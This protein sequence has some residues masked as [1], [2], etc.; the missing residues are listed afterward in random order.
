MALSST[1]DC[2]TQAGKSVNTLQEGVN[3]INSEIVGYIKQIAIMQNKVNTLITQRD[4]LIGFQR[5]LINNIN[6]TN[7]ITYLKPRQ[8]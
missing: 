7:N 2:V 8:R 5:D 1:I 6:A 3:E 4:T